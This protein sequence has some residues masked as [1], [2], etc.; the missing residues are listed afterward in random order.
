MSEN[1]NIDNL[2]KGLLSDDVRAVLAIKAELYNL[3]VSDEMLKWAEGYLKDYQGPKS[4]AL[5]TQIDISDRK[6]F[7]LVS[8]LDSDGTDPIAKIIT[9]IIDNEVG[10][11]DISEVDEIERIQFYRSLIEAEMSYKFGY[12]FKIASARG[13]HERMM[14]YYNLNQLFNELI[15]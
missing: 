1:G 9:D 14:M 10:D 6:V 3:R 7:S 8:M 11:G 5:L 13:D 12:A 4:R 15:N 2:L